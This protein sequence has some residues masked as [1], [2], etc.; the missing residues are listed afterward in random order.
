VKSEFFIE[1]MRIYVY[2]GHYFQK[3]LH[4]LREDNPVDNDD[5]N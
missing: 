3:S 1:N 5:T 4:L 2:N